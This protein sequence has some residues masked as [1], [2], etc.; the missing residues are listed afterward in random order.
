[1]STI[2]ATD[3]EG[4]F[5]GPFIYSSPEAESALNALSLILI[6][7][8]AL[9]LVLWFITKYVSTYETRREDYKFDNPGKNPSSLSAVLYIAIVESFLKQ[10]F[11]VSYT[12]H[13]LFTALGYFSLDIFYS[14]NLLC[15]INISNT[16]KFVLKSI[17][18]HIDQLALTFMLAM[19]VVYLYTILVMTYFHDT[20]AFDDGSANK[21]CNE[22]YLCYFYVLN[23]GFRNGGGFAESLNAVSTRDRFAG[24]TF[25]DLSF[26]ML[27]N[28]ISLKVIFGIIIDTFSQLRDDQNERSK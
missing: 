22:M 4:N 13:L 2:R 18:L 15:I 11:P 16:T 28:V 1:M 9:M 21:I 25:F 12:L 10:N 3:E 17:M 7:I 6:V 20:L 14:F 26:F 24:R 19:F 27:I 8:S 23:L 5:F